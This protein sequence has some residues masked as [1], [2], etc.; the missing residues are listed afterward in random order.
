MIRAVRLA[1]AGAGKPVDT[2]VLD[3]D[4]RHRRRVAMKG[5]DGLEFLLDLPEA[6]ALRDG[7]LLALEDGQLV[8]VKAAFEPLTRVIARDAAHLVRIA[9]H[10]GN[11]HLPAQLGDA[12]I[13]IRR[14]HVIEDMLRG[15]GAT[16]LHVRAP[17]EPEGGAY[18]QGGHDHHGHDHHGH[19]HHDHDHGHPG[20]EHGHHDH[21][22]AHDHDHGHSHDHGHDHSH[23]HD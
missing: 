3:H 20:H 18:A 5:E 4:S 23:H 8:E 13:F 12:F 22:H 10:L 1:E 17:F 16:V 21:G 7:D 11:R 9:W 6:R 2:V 15:L 14:D 19:D